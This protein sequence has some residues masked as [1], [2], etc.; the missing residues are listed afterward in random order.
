MDDIDSDI[1]DEFVINPISDT[2]G[3]ASHDVEQ[4]IFLP[5]HQRCASHTLNL[6]VTTDIKKAFSKQQNVTFERI[7]HS[8]FGKL[9]ALWN[10]TS[11]SPKACETYY[12]ITN[13]SPL[14]PCPTRWNSTFD[15]LTNLLKVR[16]HLREICESLN[17][18]KFKEV[19]IEFLAEYQEVLK[20]FAESLDNLQGSKNTFYGELIPELI[21]LIKIMKNY[22]TRNLKFCF[23]LV[24][25]LIESLK[26]RFPMY[27]S[28]PLSSCDK[29]ALL[30]TITHPYFK[31]RWAPKEDRKK[32]QEIFLNELEVS[33]TEN[34]ISQT[35]TNSYRRVSP[36]YFLFEDISEDSGTDANMNNKVQLQGLQYLQNND[37]N[38]SMLELYPDVKKTFIKYNTAIPSSAPVERLF[39]Y[40]GMI[41]RPK[42]RCMSDDI[43]EKQLILKANQ[44]I[45]IE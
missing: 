14:S 4:D 12:N 20:P 1:E 26:R 24:N 13:A 17:L 36:E 22:Q 19:E 43:F 6:I 9:S 38:L 44:K 30:A 25:I 8:S 23:N 34:K 18:T 37:T 5:E 16:D 10:L 42:R 28:D 39:S 21:R 40:A 3:N 7:Y 11:K 31:L 33:S 27:L 15:C 29:S 45:N 41:L 35:E 32:L 2:I